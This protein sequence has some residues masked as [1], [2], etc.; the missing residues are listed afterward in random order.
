MFWDAEHHL[1]AC[2]NLEFIAVVGPSGCEVFRLSVG[3]GL[4]WD[5]EIYSKD[6]FAFV[7]AKHSSPCVV[8]CSLHNKRNGLTADPFLMPIV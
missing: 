5:S 8:V 1:V 6:Q 3:R 4:H 2:R 7:S